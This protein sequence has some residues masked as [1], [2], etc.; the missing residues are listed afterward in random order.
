MDW[1]ALLGLHPN[2]TKEARCLASQYFDILKSSSDG[3]Q[4][5]MNVLQQ[6]IV[7]TSFIPQNIDVDS[8]LFYCMQVKW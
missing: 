7:D 8:A 4:L 5:C 6:S 2:A 3:W 1:N